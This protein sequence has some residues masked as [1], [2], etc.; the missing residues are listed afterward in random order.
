MMNFTS[1]GVKPLD[2]TRT[3]RILAGNGV[4]DNLIPADYISFPE[5][6]MVRFN[7]E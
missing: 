6:A 7:Q 4:K 3:A 2:M 1:N 5:I